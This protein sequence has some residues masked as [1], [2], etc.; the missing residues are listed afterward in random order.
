[1]IVTADRANLPFLERG[2]D[3]GR[4]LAEATN[5]ARDLVN[6]PAN[7]MTPTHMAEVAV[8]LA[9]TYGLEINVL[10]LEE[11]KELGIGRMMAYQYTPQYQ[12]ILSPALES[13]AV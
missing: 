7:Y 11:L 4:I 9:E 2:S 10:E 3:K 6:E 13:F 5:R 8:K 1:M 12:S